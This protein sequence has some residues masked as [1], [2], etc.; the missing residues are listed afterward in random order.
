[1]TQFTRSTS[2]KLELCRTRWSEDELTRLAHIV[3]QH[4]GRVD[5]RVTSADGEDHFRSHDP[6][7]LLGSECPPAIQAIEMKGGAQGVECEVELEIPQRDN[8]LNIKA[9]M[10]STS[11]GDRAAVT[12]LFRDL[13]KA[14]IARRLAGGRL[15]RFMSGPGGLLVAFITSASVLLALYYTL[16][17]FTHDRFPW[18]GSS[19]TGRM[20]SLAGWGITLA[21]AVPLAPRVYRLIADSFPPVEFSGR[22]VPSNRFRRAGFIWVVVFVLLPFLVNLVS[23]AAFSEIA[24]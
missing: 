9:A 16:I 23:S 17:Q 18:L 6:A 2:F 15:V 7:F 10:A 19:A 21:C 3:A 11:G 24:K 20:M 1:M 13:Q 12:S 4:L 14:F 5:I 22:F 8:Y